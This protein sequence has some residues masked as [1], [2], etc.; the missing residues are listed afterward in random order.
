MEQGT[1]VLVIGPISFIV[2]VICGVAIY[3]LLWHL[4]TSSIQASLAQEKS[5][6]RALQQQIFEMQ[7]ELERLRDRLRTVEEVNNELIQ[8][9]RFLARQKG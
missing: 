4:D 6:N 3:R 2:G 9:E 7:A 5:Y 1:F 8:Q